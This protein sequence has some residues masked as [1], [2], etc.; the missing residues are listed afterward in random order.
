MRTI[1][2]L[3]GLVWF[4][5]T[6]TARGEHL[7]ALRM[8]EGGVTIEKMAL[9][10]G[11]DL[12]LFCDSKGGVIDVIFPV[13]P[14]GSGSLAR[15]TDERTI[16]A[17][18]SGKEIS[19]LDR[20]RSGRQW[21]RPARSID[22]LHN[23][24]IR[25]SV[26]SHEGL[27]KAFLIR[28]Y[29]DVVAD[30][31]N[32][33]VDLF[34]GKI[35]TQPGDYLIHTETYE[36]K[37]DNPRSGK[38]PLEYNQ[39]LYARGRLANGS[40][41]TFVIDLGAGQTIVAKGFLPAESTISDVGVAQYSS[42]GKEILK[43]APQGATGTTQVLGSVTLPSF[44]LGEL[45]FGDVP[46][47]VMPQ[48]PDLGGR[49]VDG[50]IGLDLLRR[51]RFLTI[52]YGATAPG[53]GTLRLDSVA[54]ETE[55]TA[56]TAPFSLINSHLVVE[57][58]VNSNPVAAILDTGSPVCFLDTQAANACGVKFDESNAKEVHGLDAGSAAAR[59]GRIGDFRIADRTFPDADAMIGSL[60]VFAPLRV[61]N[62]SVG[63][64]GNSI[65]SRLS[66]L[67]ID[68]STNQI[69]FFQPND[70]TSSEKPIA[71]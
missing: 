12:N 17:K 31:V 24:D 20:A 57:T 68:F 7:F 56:H 13:G 61:H 6:S 41:G 9:T 38:A 4:A 10:D 49:H 46:V 14:G 30:P 42:A 35:P 29:K 67:V 59:R 11:Q 58:R 28:G 45:A 25:V 2:F 51:N 27:R 69:R 26:I 48:L 33:V 21:Q 65:L 44:S 3:P 50:I 15:F 16:T 66:R 40:E 22:D 64:L 5:A 60:P 54:D 39:Y 34:A 55:K 62:Q 18:Q 36:T 47:A 1:L 19:V 52:E 37:I 8:A 53:R 23:Y 63:L 71:P 70:S 43:Y 32:L